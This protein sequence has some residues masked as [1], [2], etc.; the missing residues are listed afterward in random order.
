MRGIVVEHVLAQVLVHVTDGI[1]AVHCA[2]VIGGPADI[3][4]LPATSVQAMAEPAMDGARAE[5]FLELIDDKVDGGGIRVVANRVEHLICAE[6][7]QLLRVLDV[8]TRIGAAK[9]DCDK[10]TAEHAR[11]GFQL[12]VYA[13]MRAVVGETG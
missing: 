2:R 5:R 1:R 9:G 3:I 8:Q 6:I 13:D 10:Q 11:D 12:L 7:V 4:L